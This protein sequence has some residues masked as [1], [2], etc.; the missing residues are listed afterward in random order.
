MNRM[1]RLCTFDSGDKASDEV[2][3]RFGKIVHGFAK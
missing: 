1:A 3:L 2:K